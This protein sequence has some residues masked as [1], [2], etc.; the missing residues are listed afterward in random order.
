MKIRT[1]QQDLSMNLCRIWFKRFAFEG[2]QGALSLSEQLRSL[3]KTSGSP[4]AL[5]QGFDMDFVRCDILLAWAG[6]E[7]YLRGAI[8]LLREHWFSVSRSNALLSSF[9]CLRTWPMPRQIGLAAI[10]RMKTQGVHLSFYLNDIKV[11]FKGDRFLCRVYLYDCIINKPLFRWRQIAQKMR[12]VFW[13]Y[14][15]FA[16][17]L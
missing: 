4:P 14:N 12:P 16:T 8:M 7:C 3:T 15:Y 17:R 11:Y 6:W 2:Q 1:T 9:D 10:R 13:I 5:S